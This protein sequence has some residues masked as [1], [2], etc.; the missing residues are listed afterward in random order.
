MRDITLLLVD[1]HDVV[2][3]G[4]KAFLETQE[5]MRVVAEAATGAEAL[6]RAA[7]FRPDIV[8]MDLV[9]PSMDGFQVLAEKSR[10]PS[11]NGIPVIVISARDPIG[12]PMLGN[13]LSVSQSGGFTVAN[14]MDYLQ[15]MSNVLSPLAK[16]G[17]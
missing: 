6:E 10:D 17:K 1:D 8:L 2:R 3:T 7:E 15:V 5:G 14:L 16:T 13:T 12:E 11:I 9:M 4:L